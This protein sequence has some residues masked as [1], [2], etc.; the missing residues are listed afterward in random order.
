MSR[1]HGVPVIIPS[2]A[3]KRFRGTKA[4]ACPT[5]TP[6]SACRGQ[7]PQEK[8][9]QHKKEMSRPVLTFHGGLDLSGRVRCVVKS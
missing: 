3:R 7:Q 4:A 8:A 1:Y 5:S 9:R 2:T 6:L